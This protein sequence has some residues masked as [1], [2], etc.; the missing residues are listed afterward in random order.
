MQTKTSNSTG[1]DVILEVKELTKYYKCDDTEDNIISIIGFLKRKEDL[2]IKGVSFD[3]CKGRIIGLIG[4]KKCGKS[5]LL[6]LISGLIKPSSGSIFYKGLKINNQQLREM[7]SYISKEQ[8]SSQEYNCSLFENLI[9]YTCREQKERCD[10]VDRA[11]KLIT[12]FDIEEY[13]YKEVIKLPSAIRSKMFIIRGLLSHKTV[14]CFDQ[15]L[16]FI[17]EKYQ[18]TFK[19]YMDQLVQ[20]GKTI[21]ISSDEENI[22]ER[23]CNE[24]ITLD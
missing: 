4:K 21:I 6:K 7:V 19:K 9:Q 12:D 8:P 2:G 20:A 15:P 5:T 24:I 18:D 22:I 17:E 14:L 11:E 23:I 13:K 16:M 10:V 1:A 3:I